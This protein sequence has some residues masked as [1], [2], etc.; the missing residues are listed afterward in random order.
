MVD[1]KQGGA[2]GLQVIGLG[3]G[4]TGTGSVKLALEKLGYKTLHMS[5]HPKDLKHFSVKWPEIYKK[6]D[7]GTIT[8][9]DWDALFK[10][11]TATQDFPTCMF[12]RELIVAYPDAKYILTVRDDPKKWHASVMNTI[13]KTSIFPWWHLSWLLRPQ[14]RGIKKI[15]NRIWTNF[16][17][18][19]VGQDGAAV[20]EAH[21]V[22]CKKIIPQSQLLVYNVKEGWKPMCKFLGKEIPDGEFPFE[23]EGQG[24]GAGIDAYHRQLLKEFTRFVLGGTGIVGLAALLLLNRRTVVSFLGG[25][26]Y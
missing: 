11:Y 15:S 7:D 1:V 8:R 18:G 16:F 24:M 6:I 20:Y 13:G 26:R 14:T 25:L 21:I 9:A 10:D 19:R 17:H 5:E 12:P 4:R 22:E 2:G 23:H 3:L